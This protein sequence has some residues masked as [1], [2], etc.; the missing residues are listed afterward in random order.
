M[1]SPI[2]IGISKQLDIARFTDQSRLKAS[3][4]GHER[5]S[6]LDK[7]RVACTL[8]LPKYRIVLFGECHNHNMW[9]KRL[10]HNYM[11]KGSRLWHQIQSMRANMYECENLN[12]AVSVPLYTLHDHELLWN[13]VISLTLH[14]PASLKSRFKVFE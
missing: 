10:H 12:P 11:K 5:F 7:N 1:W 14:S 8:A 2:K 9:L 4:A 6:S 3:D 13:N